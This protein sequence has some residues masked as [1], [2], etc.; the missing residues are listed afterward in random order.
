MLALIAH[1]LKPVKLF[2]P[3]KRTQHCWPCWE[4]FALVASVCIGLNNNQALIK[5][6]SFY[7]I[8]AIL[9]LD[10]SEILFSANFL[11]ISKKTCIYSLE[12]ENN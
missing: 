2:G 12:Y 7:N 3:C 11:E 1:S 5:Q 10:F 6:Q 8:S 9:T 4:L